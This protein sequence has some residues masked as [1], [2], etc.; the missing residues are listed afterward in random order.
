MVELEV[1]GVV[2]ETRDRGREVLLSV[3]QRFNGLYE[4]CVA[5]LSSGVRRMAEL[6]MELRELRIQDREAFKER[7]RNGTPSGSWELCDE[8]VRGDFGGVGRKGRLEYQE[9]RP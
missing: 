6:M 3:T 1:P 4:E 8:A 2:V 5:D 9:P 7:R